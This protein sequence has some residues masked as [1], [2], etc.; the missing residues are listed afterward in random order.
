MFKG[1]FNC[2]VAFILLFKGCSAV[3]DTSEKPK[4]VPKIDYSKSSSILTENLIGKS[5]KSFEELY[6]GSIT[7]NEMRTDTEKKFT[8][9]FIKGKTGV[10]KVD[11]ILDYYFKYLDEKE[12]NYLIDEATNTV[13]AINN[14]N[15]P[16]LDIYIT[17][18]DVDRDLQKE[19]DGRMVK[20]GSG[21]ILGHYLIDTSTGDISELK[22]E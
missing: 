17:E 7:K 12:C 2:L 20:M 4:K 22:V 10:N 19:K 1:G 11:Y 21:L 9:T 3:F 16:I 5:D 6:S 13:T 18:Y 15:S 8:Y 14:I